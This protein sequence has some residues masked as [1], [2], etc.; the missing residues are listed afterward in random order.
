MDFLFAI[1][2]GL[3]F[4]IAITKFG[5]PVILDRY[6][7]APDSGI[8]VIY[9]SW[10]PHWA[11]WFFVPMALF[12]L[13]AVDWGRLKFHW[14]L[15]LPLAWFLWQCIAATQTVD[16]ALTRLTMTHFAIAV[17]L[18]YIGFFATSRIANPWPIW[19][20]IGLA[21]IWSMRLG[22]E[23][24]FG[25]LEAT[26]KMLLISPKFADIDPDFLKRVSTGRIFGTFDNPNTLA[27]AIVLILPVT[28][29]FLWRLSP[30]LRKSI[31]V[32][33]VVVLGGCGLACI[34]WS[35]SK[36]GWLV[37]MI[38]GLVAL[39]Y[40]GLSKRWK[41]GVICGCLA[42]GSVAFAIKYE[43]YFKKDKNSMGAR[44]AYWRAAGIII[45]K[46]PLLGT[47]P[48][49]FQVPY[50]QIRRPGDEVAKL[51]HNDYLEQA[52]DSG[53]LGCVVYVTTIFSLFALLY[54][55]FGA[56]LGFDWLELG[57][58]LGLFGMCLHSLV[59]FHLYVTGLAW[60]MFFLFGWLL[61]RIL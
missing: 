59:D 53:I 15:V 14:V 58:G 52:T 55:Y 38:V 36:A 7:T 19:V 34:F 61:R 49:T 50:L 37:L 47:G 43:A 56:K 57:V 21:L 6:I 39:A 4:F 16:S 26:R 22:L 45:K 46:H 1:V 18:F 54:R 42:L 2:A 27:G 8:G 60:L 17:A 40:S 29:V 32:L 25:G 13:L 44:F 9:E 24:H 33:F 35:G 23:Q 31:R 48:G 51:C 20:G 5:S 3:F 41:W 28:L 10:P 11:P 30:K 12:A